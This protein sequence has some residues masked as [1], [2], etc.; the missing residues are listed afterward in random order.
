MAMTEDLLKEFDEEMATTRRLL[1]RVPENK[2][3]WK[4]HDKSTPLG[5]LATHVA[6]LPNFATRILDNET[7]DAATFTRPPAF[8]T[9][10]ALVA[11]F[12]EN[13][14]NALHAALKDLDTAFQNSQ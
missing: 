9:T 4:P 10:A 3:D 8:S 14:R 7:L 13:V 11:F 2:K 12:D 6:N 1:E 5:N